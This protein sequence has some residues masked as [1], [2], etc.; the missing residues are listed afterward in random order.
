V[1]R[2][3]VRWELAVDV[4]VDVEL[5]FALPVTD[6]GWLT[7]DSDINNKHFPFRYA[8]WRAFVTSLQAPSSHSSPRPRK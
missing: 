4:D 8:V 6:D 2:A 3:D 1:R 7:V 5:P